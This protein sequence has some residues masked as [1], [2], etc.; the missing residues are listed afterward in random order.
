MDFTVSLLILAIAAFLQNMAFTAV[1]RSR[2][3]GDPSYHRWC[4]Y[5][6]NSIWFVTHFMVLREVWGI[7]DVG[8]GSAWWRLVVIGV[9][10]GVATAE[11]SV[12]MMKRLLKSEKGKRMV[13][14]R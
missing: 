11:G 4:A 13:G 6:S 7:L 5:A 8:I 9:V 14:S 3:S 12:L 10:Y 2:N 1:S